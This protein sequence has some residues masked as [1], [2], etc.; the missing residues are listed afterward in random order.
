MKKVIL[1]V[2]TIISFTPFISAQTK[3]ADEKA[4]A[5]VINTM[6]TG[7]NEKNGEIYASGFADVH[8]FI[9]LTGEYFP[10]ST[11]KRIAAGIQGLFNGPFKMIDL[12]LNIDKIKFIRPDIA[13]T[14]VLGGSYDKGKE[15]PKDPGVLM[16]LLLEKKKGKWQIISFHNL[17]L[18]IFQNEEMAAR[19][20]VPLKIMFASWYKK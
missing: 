14:H 9:A 19:S 18:K 17:D 2:F 10:N 15:A 16:S 11:P 7:W 13:L 6:Q 12:K 4:I 20:P 1:A 3:K 8:D 5:A